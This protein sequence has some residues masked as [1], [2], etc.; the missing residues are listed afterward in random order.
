MSVDGLYIRKGMEGGM[1]MYIW[2]I[3]EGEGEGGGEGR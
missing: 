2:D 3:G 1:D